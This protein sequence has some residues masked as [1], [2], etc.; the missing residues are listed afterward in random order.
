[1]RRTHTRKT[2]LARGSGGKLDGQ[3]H[4]SEEVLQ[5]HGR[6]SC[7]VRGIVVKAPARQPWLLST[8]PVGRTHIPHHARSQLLLEPEHAPAVVDRCARA[9]G[10]T[11][12]LSVDTAPKPLHRPVLDVGQP[13]LLG[14][15]EPDDSVEE[16]AGSERVESRAAVRVG[17]GPVAA[18]RQ[19]PRA[20]AVLRLLLRHRARTSIA[21]AR[22]LCASVGK[23]RSTR[24]APE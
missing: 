5:I 17:L 19:A 1:M 22:R 10:L 16:R 14:G 8:R 6:H 21:R 12:R 15:R 20:A 13:R 9:A 24:P 3:A 7:H 18:G 2:D 11:Q 4:V 23:A